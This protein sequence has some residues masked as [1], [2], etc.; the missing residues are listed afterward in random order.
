MGYHPDQCVVSAPS[1]LNAEERVLQALR[2]LDHDDRS[3]N[4]FSP[5]K[6]NGETHYTTSAGTITCVKAKGQQNTYR[7]TGPSFIIKWLVDQGAIDGFMYTRQLE[8][9]SHE[10]RER[11]VAQRAE[12]LRR[13]PIYLS[14][15]ATGLQIQRAKR[16]FRAN[17]RADPRVSSASSS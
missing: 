15:L 6:L 10:R 9:E 12:E 11:E 17:L 2:A 1:Q 8:G 7:V 4:A 13:D 16:A 14:G 3:S 5:P